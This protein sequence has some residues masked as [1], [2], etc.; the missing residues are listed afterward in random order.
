MHI[1]IVEFGLKDI[2][3]ADYRSACAGLA[4]VLARVPGLV[5]LAWL[6]DARTNTY[7]GVYTWLDRTAME[8]YLRSD[9]FAAVAADPDL[10]NI[11]WRAFDLLD[12]PS[13]ITSGLLGSP[14]QGHDPVD[15]ARTLPQ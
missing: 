14:G 15:N 2:S 6:A 13:R 8:A 5:S 10:V 12:E 4:K 7:G 9:I 11:R 1:Q 3:D